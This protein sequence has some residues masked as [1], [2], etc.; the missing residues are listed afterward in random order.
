MSVAILSMSNSPTNINVRCIL[1]MVSSILSRRHVIRTML[2]RC[3]AVAIL[4]PLLLAPSPFPRTR[5]R[6][7]SAM[8]ERPHEKNRTEQQTLYHIYPQHTSLP[9]A[10]TLMII[11]VL[12]LPIGAAIIAASDRAAL[13]DFR[14]DHISKYSYVQGSSGVYAVDY[15]FDGAI[16]STGI[17]TIVKFTLQKSLAAPIYI[18]YGLTNFYQN[19]RQFGESIDFVQIGGGREKVTDS[20]EPFRYPGEFTNS[21]VPGYYNPCGALAWSLFNDTFRLSSDVGT[22][23]CDGAAFSASGDSLNP[24]N[25]CSKRGIALKSDVKTSKEPKPSA[26]P[27]PMWSAA[28]DSS[29]SDPFLNEGY[30][31]GEPGHRIPSSIDEDFI[32]WTSIAYLGD[33]N[34]V[35]RIIN[36]DIPA[37]DYY[38]SITELFDS[39]QYSGEK[40]VQLITRTWIGG[41]NY[42]LGILLTALGSVSFVVAIAVIALRLLTTTKWKD[43]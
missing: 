20:C 26:D 5:L 4:S 6:M 33:F 34:K 17:N 42:P 19:F 24:N 41:R 37:G 35:Y 10:I 39:R 29:A 18:Q 15:T 25:K 3:N 8:T 11:T 16:Y 1:N 14:Y 7:P 12:C 27:G 9:V 36:E 13:L 38:F 30:Y 23:I 2:S 21:R 31:Y 43:I 22:L 40:H 28:G 32:V